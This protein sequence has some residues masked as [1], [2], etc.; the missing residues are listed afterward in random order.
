MIG[1]RS[2]RPPGRHRN[3]QPHT[4][5]HRRLWDGPARAEAERMER[6][7]PTWL[8]LYSLGNRRFYAIAGWPAPEPVIVCDDTSEG[9][10][11][12]MRQ[13]ETV[14]TWQVLPTSSSPTGHG[15]VS[16]PAHVPASPARAA[17]SPHPYRR[18]A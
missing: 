7:W 9:L 18:V 8:V 4:S 11:E 17:V 1:L 13:Q 3:G 5:V 12:Q 15:H 10:E 14:F 16:S 2:S 6:S